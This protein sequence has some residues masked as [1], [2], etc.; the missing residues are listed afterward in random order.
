ML[1]DLIRSVV[2]SD[3]AFTR[4]H[5]DSFW[6]G[7]VALAA[8]ASLRLMFEGPALHTYSNCIARS[9]ISANDEL[10]DLV[11]AMQV[12]RRKHAHQARYKVRRLS[13]PNTCGSLIPRAQYFGAIALF[14]QAFRKTTAGTS[15]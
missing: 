10:Q 9:A 3:S 11:Q 14:L 5:I 15:L 13:R 2:P 1:R 7:V 8:C 6:L 12:F 4:T